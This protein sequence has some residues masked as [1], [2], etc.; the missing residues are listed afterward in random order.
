MT[1]VVLFLAV[2]NAAPAADDLAER[3][4]RASQVYREL[5]ET[6]DKAIPEA[7]LRDCRCV[8]VLPKVIKG[9]IGFGVRKGDGVVTCRN[10]AGEWSPLA[11]FQ[12]AGGSWGLQLGAEVT[13]LVLFFMTER[14]AQSLL[15]SRVTLGGKLSV[16]AGPAGRSAEASTD[17]R[18][19]AEIY[20]YA[21][22]KGLFAG[23]SLE[24]ARLAPNKSAIARYYGKPVSARELLFEHQA[25]RRSPEMEA[26]L[27]SLPAKPD[28]LQGAR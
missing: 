8:A 1:L 9:A 21:K 24:G 10:A 13:D 27:A 17:V 3:V 5:I 19:E 11:F 26:F 6:P 4:T 22:S 16:A 15:E 12:L 2:P 18:F 28:T 7:L 23:I 14:G 20:S 25:P